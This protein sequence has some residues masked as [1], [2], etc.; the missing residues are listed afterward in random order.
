MMKLILAMLAAALLPVSTASAARQ[1]VAVAFLEPKTEVDIDVV[2]GALSVGGYQRPFYEPEY[3]K[4]RP[5]LAGF[6]DPYTHGLFV[7]RS[8][9]IPGLVEPDRSL[10]AAQVPSP[11]APPWNPAQLQ[12]AGPHLERV[13]L[14]DGRYAEV[15]TDENGRALTVRW[16]TAQGPWVTSNISYGKDRTT[17]RMPFGIDRTYVH[18]SAGRITRILV[19]GAHRHA[20]DDTVDGMLDTHATG[21]RR[22]LRLPVLGSAE[23]A[24]EAASR[25]AI[26]NIYDDQAFNG[27]YEVFGVNSIAAAERINRLLAHLGLLDVAEAMPELRS[28][29]EFTQEARR[30][31]PLF[32]MLG[33]CV[34]S[35]GIRLSAGV[36]V[37]IARTITAPEV[38]RLDGFLAAIPDW[39]YIRL[40]L[41]G[42]VRYARLDA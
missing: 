42:R 35:T 40:G 1:A 22:I 27:G 13:V 25:D 39:V 17:V 16:P 34:V 41:A 8:D 36:E 31:G 19:P 23:H 10:G 18:D 3:R 20:T 11:G 38:E 6:V 14:A 30:F 21:R 15:E 29:A 5:E 33:P 4:E 32:K 28:F 37:S 2:S 24:I 7:Y 9:G 12:S 26:G